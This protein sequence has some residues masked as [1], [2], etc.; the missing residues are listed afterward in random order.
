MGLK[1]TMETINKEKV[2]IRSY[3]KMLLNCSTVLVVSS[4]K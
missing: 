2:I 1:S 3:L 4:L